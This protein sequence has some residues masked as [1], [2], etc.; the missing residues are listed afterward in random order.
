MARVSN[1]ARDVPLG[2]GKY[3]VRIEY[4]KQSF[5]RG[6]DTT[7]GFGLDSVPS[8]RIVRDVAHNLTSIAHFLPGLEVIHAFYHTRS[9]LLN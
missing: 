2:N 7:M 3:V 4:S 5:C 6:R 1:L 9:A 8:Q